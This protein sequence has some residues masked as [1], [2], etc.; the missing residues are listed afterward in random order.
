MKRFFLFAF[1]LV[2]T[3]SF[4]QNWTTNLEEAKATAAKENKNI[5]LV[6]SGSDWC[7]P[8]I[9]LDKNVWQSTEFKTYADGKFVLLRA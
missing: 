2:T 8:C 5:L 1:V 4:A 3:N 9:K 7:A 6:F